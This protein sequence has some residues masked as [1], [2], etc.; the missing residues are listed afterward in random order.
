MGLGLEPDPR[1]QEDGAQGD[2]CVPRV[3]GERVTHRERK[4][5]WRQLSVWSPAC[6]TPRASAGSALWTTPC[7]I[8]W[9]AENRATLDS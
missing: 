5:F 7:I 1:P 9:T 3:V 6:W 8:L 4:G 2:S